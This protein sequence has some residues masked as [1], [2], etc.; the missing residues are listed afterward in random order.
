MSSIPYASAIE[1]I[2]YSI[3]CTR[4][5]VS[6]ALSITSRYQANPGEQQWMAVKIILKY[7]KRA[8]DMF[9]MYGDSIEMKVIGYYDAS[10]QTDRD[11]I[12]SQIGYLFIL[13]G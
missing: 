2:M 10:F 9:L 11:D 5:G 3:L 1:S 8:K 6:Y 7:L 4:P 12:I 13:N